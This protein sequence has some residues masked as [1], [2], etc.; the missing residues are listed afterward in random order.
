MQIHVAKSQVLD[1]AHRS[2]EIVERKG[3]GHPDTLCDRAAEEVSIALSRYYR[4]HFG[5]VLHHNT[6]KVLL[7]G[8]RAYTT[9]GRGEVL[10]PIYLLLSGRA[11]VSVDGEPV[12]VGALAL[13]H[14]GAWL[15][16]LLPR[17]QLPGNLII[18]YR[19]KPSSP[20]LMGIFRR[21]GVPLANDSSFTVAYAPL[22]AL[23]R[24]VHQ[25]E[26]HLNSAD[27][28][29]QYPQLGRDIKV[30]GLRTEDRIALTIAAAFIAAETPDVDA[31]LAG[32]ETVAALASEVAAAV[33]D[34]EVHVAVN[35]AD[36]LEAGH[37]FL[38]VTGTSAEQGDDGQVGRGNRVNGLITP[39]RPMTLEAAAGKN[40]VSHVGKLYQVYAQCIVDRICA[41]VPE[42]Q[43][44]TC[45]LLSRIGTPINEPQAVDVRVE[46]ELGEAAL[47]DIVPGLIHAVLD[48]WAAI[49][50]GFLERRW[51]LF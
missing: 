1:V 45:S 51:P 11:T 48:D 43:A 29:R 4:E 36:Q 32:K 20:E 9:F 17:L 23:E 5:A 34:H 27:I 3:V 50:D 47:R 28:Q 40:P 35:A 2:V 22:S 26:H 10:D 42:V 30:M 41:E 37:A 13:Q 16:E 14:T 33:S 8:G 6:D 44:A 25:V 12:P 31:Y 7:V 39:M 18:D 24:T 19:I 49:R 46:S 15:Q 38:T 21:Q